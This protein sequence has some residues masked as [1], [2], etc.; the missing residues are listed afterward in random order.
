MGPD[1]ICAALA[2]LGA[3]PVLDPEMWP[4]GPQDEDRVRLLG[5]LLAK[6]EL[7]LTAAIRL[8][9]QELDDLADAVFGWLDQVG[10]EGALATNVLLNRLQRTAVQIVGRGED[11]ETPAGR[12]AAWACVVA[13]VDALSA[14]LNF[15]QGDVEGVRRAL[16]RTETALITVLEGMHDLRVAI[17]D[18]EEEEEE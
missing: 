14:E 9:D 3:A 11:E 7:E 4:E 10:T 17:G 16:G 12:V 15:Q 1:A 8:G 6:V 5:S 18:A 2:A 13:A